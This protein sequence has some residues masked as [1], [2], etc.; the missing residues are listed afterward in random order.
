[1]HAIKNTY[2]YSDVNA[3][4]SNPTSCAESIVPSDLATIASMKVEYSPCKKNC[5]AEDKIYWVTCLLLIRPAKDVS[6][7]STDLL[8]L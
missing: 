4:S 1:M 8:K 5:H 3:F 7:P 2:G 6:E